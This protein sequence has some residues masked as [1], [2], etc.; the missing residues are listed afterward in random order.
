MMRRFRSFFKSETVRP[1]SLLCLL[2]LLLPVA[3]G[4]Q[5]SYTISDFEPVGF[6]FALDGQILE[7]ADD[8]DTGRGGDL[9]CG[10]R[11]AGGAAAVRRRSHTADVS[12]RN[13]REHLRRATPLYA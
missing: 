6:Q 12:S 13:L 5:V 9:D 3:I 7:D 11:L 8:T 2:I 10:E 1:L 4:A